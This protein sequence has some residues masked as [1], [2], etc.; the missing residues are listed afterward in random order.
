MASNESPPRAALLSPPLSSPLS[1]PRSPWTSADVLSP[2]PGVTGVDG[3]DGVVCPP[4]EEQVVIDIAGESI[5]SIS[6][7]SAHAI[8]PVAVKSAAVNSAAVN[9]NALSSAAAA[10]NY[11]A[12][13]SA[14]DPHSAERAEEGTRIP[15]PPSA[16]T[17]APLQ[18]EQ[19]RGGTAE[20]MS[21]PA[22][23]SGVPPPPSALTTAELMC[24][25][26]LAQTRA[27]TAEESLRALEQAVQ[28]AQE[29]GAGEVGEASE[30]GE[31]GDV[32]ISATDKRQAV[33]WPAD[34]DELREGLRK[35]EEFA[36]WQEQGGE[37][38]WRI[39]HEEEPWGRSFERSQHVALAI[40]HVAPCSALRATPSASYYSATFSAPPS[41]PPQQFL[42]PPAV[43]PSLSR[44]LTAYPD[45]APL[46][47][48]C[49]P[50][51]PHAAV[52]PTSG[53][54][55][56]QFYNRK[57]W[58]LEEPLCEP[59]GNVIGGAGEFPASANDRG[60]IRKYPVNEEVEVFDDGDS[61]SIAWL[62]QVVLAMEEGG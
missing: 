22:E 58:G 59:R 57:A 6:T 36:T 35:A 45:P 50:M 3:V 31:A 44:H 2:P 38:G 5:R 62:V 55:F 10:V 9:S 8:S 61:W 34:V 16:L 42:S 29:R 54:V 37:G 33:R 4:G 47:L 27:R 18:P 43:P 19:T 56:D 24:A 17:T 48:P 28:A 11:A 15:L 39:C 25:L 12:V 41:L 7:T 1:P 52:S 53:Y 13:T 14:A 49:S 23:G 21:A 46:C 40:T 60:G 26:Q 20:I 30:A 51:L 32:Q